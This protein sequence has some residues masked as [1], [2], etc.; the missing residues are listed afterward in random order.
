VILLIAGLVIFLGV[1]SAQ[2]FAAGMRD[3]FIARRGAG[4]WKGLY[5]LLSAIGLV[6]LIKGYGDARSMPALWTAPEGAELIT[7]ALVLLGFILVTAAYWPGN[8]IKA[9][10][11]DPMVLGVGAWAL[12][13]LAVKSSPP[14]L[15]LF[16]GFL[17]WAVLDFISLRRRPA[18]I[19][20][21]GAGAAP[22]LI[23]T[24]GVVVLGAGLSVVFAI[25]G[26]LP[27]IGVRPLG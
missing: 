20:G 2:I 4:A 22:K 25:W 11:K 23:N 15:A 5:A 8:H 26:H 6:L 9:A 3:A 18:V 16:G 10:V 17:V 19:G 12:G 24:A 27:L 14:A 13:H 21:V 7:V 1:H